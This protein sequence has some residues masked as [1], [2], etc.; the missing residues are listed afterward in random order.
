VLK[1]CLEELFVMKFMNTDPNF[2]NFLYDPN[3]DKI[4]LLDFGATRMFD[5]LFT[6]NYARLLQSGVSD[7]KLASIYWSKKLG[8]LTGFESQVYLYL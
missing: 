5:D 6:Y 3:N 8:F 1:L 7:D 2:S 4:K